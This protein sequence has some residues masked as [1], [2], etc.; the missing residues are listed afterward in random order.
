MQMK[1]VDSEIMASV[2]SDMNI[3]LIITAGEERSL[4]SVDNYIC[5]RLGLNIA[6]QCNIV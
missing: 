6:D 1:S 3:S 2:M 5:S 4:V